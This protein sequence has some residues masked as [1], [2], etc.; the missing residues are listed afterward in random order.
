MSTVSRKNCEIQALLEQSAF[1][2]IAQTWGYR[3]D[4]SLKTKPLTETAARSNSTGPLV[5]QSI[6]NL[7]SFKRAPSLQH[8]KRAPGIKDPLSRG[9]RQTK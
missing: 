2:T 9:E 4:S 7:I 5:A 8:T 1:P 3:V 6:S